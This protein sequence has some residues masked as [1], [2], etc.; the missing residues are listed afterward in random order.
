ML[1]DSSQNRTLPNS[2]C[3]KKRRFAKAQKIMSK[4]RAEIAKMATSRN[5]ALSE[6]HAVRQEMELLR[7]DVDVTIAASERAC[8]QVGPLC[9]CPRATSRYPTCRRSSAPLHPPGYPAAHPALAVLASTP[10]AWSCGGP[11]FG[12]LQ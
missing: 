4:E 10:A 1:R 5:L 6:C 8:I 2:S 9:P 3:L 11:P 7:V 12:S